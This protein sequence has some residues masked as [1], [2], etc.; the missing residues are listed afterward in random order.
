MNQ[1]SWN[2]T[3]E[4]LP[5][6]QPNTDGIVC[7]VVTDKGN[8][9]RARYMHDV[10]EGGESKYWSEFS[11][12]YN[13]REDEHYEITEKVVFWLPMPCEEQSK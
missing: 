1:I 3:S 11:I 5:E 7:V 9:Y 10:H 2:K 13:G 4:Q 8:A 12:G 6:T